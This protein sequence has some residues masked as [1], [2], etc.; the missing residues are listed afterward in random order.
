MKRLLNVIAVAALTA[1][2][3]LTA[4]AGDDQH[5]EGDIVV[6]RTGANTLTVEYNFPAPTVLT[7]VSG[8]LNGWAGDEPGFD[9]LEADEPDEDIYTLAPGVRVVFEL[10]SIDPA[11]VGNPLTEPLDSPGDTLLLG[12]HELHQHIDWLIDSDGPSFNP[13]QTEWSVMFRLSDSGTTGYSDSE[14]YSWHFT[15]VPEPA[16][17]G[18]LLVGAVAFVRRRR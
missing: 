7:P 11:L 12:D 5:H 8:L 9:H 17:V 4:Q 18:L 6:G 2:F 16:T 1:V 15:N 14:V 3:P 13:V 10:V